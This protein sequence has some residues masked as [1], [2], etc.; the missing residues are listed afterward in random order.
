MSESGDCIFCKIVEGDIPSFKI[1]EDERTLAFM[2]IN[3]A[4]EGHCLVIPKTHTRD[5]FDINERDVA[6]VAKSVRRVARA[7]QA[8]LQPDG[9]N[10][11]QSNGAAAGQSVFHFHMHVLPRR[12]GDGLKMNWGL[13]SGDLQAIGAL[14]ARIAQNME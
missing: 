8:T 3:P 4:N 2:D 11:A 13:K 10:L 1:F 7:V 5:V 14:A 6:A 12:S 9:I